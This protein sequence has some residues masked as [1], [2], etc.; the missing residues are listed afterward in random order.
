MSTDCKS[1][2]QTFLA[3]LSLSKRA[4]L[5]NDLLALQEVHRL[6]NQKV[7]YTFKNFRHIA[8]RHCERRKRSLRYVNNEA[9]EL[10]IHQIHEQH[11][12]KNIYK[13]QLFLDGQE[14]DEQL[15]T[16]FIDTLTAEEA[17]EHTLYY[18]QIPV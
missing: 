4:K 6:N 17:A 2:A 18:Q 1:V 5:Y 3:E 11:F 9:N 8:K 15:L 12:F 13:L 16:Q 10:V 7:Y 14:Y